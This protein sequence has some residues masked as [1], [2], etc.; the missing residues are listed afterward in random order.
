MST[1]HSGNWPGLVLGAL[2]GARD[3]TDPVPTGCFAIIQVA[4][5]VLQ[6]VQEQPRQVL[7][8]A[9]LHR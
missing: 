1:T 2:T 3:E 7:N 9:K 4:V 5:A 8:S 6:E